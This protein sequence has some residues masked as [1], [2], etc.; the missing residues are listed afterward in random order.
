MDK[1]SENDERQTRNWLDL[2]GDGDSGDSP[3]TRRC[4]DP[5]ERSVCMHFM[6]DI[7]EFG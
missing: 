7:Y 5:H 4:G 3:E 1:Q 2:P 6:A